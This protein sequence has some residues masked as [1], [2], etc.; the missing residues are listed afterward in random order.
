MNPIEKNL[1]RHIA[2]LEAFARSKGYEFNGFKAQWL[3]AHPETEDQLS[4]EEIADVKEAEKEIADG[5]AETFDTAEEMIADL[6]KSEPAVI[7]ETPKRKRKAKTNAG[8]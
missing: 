5:K 1:E 7:E 2:L 4:P 8:A 6:N 3:L